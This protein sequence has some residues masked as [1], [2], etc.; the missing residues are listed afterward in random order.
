M[1]IRNNTHIPYSSVREDMMIGDGDAYRLSLYSSIGD[2][3]MIWRLIKDFKS[4]VVFSVGFDYDIYIYIY[5]S[6]TNM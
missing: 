6:Y 5:S 3:F 1:H 4:N 2:F